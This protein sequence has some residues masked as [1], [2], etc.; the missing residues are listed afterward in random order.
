MFEQHK[1][2]KFDEIFAPQWWN[3]P[4][5]KAPKGRKEVKFENFV[6]F[7]LPLFSSCF[8]LFFSFCLCKRLLVSST[9]RWFLLLAKWRNSAHSSF[10]FFSFFREEIFPEAWSFKLFASLSK[11]VM[12]LKFFLL[13]VFYTKFKVSLDLTFKS[14]NLLIV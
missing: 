5:R 12:F 11:V 13:R 7:E 6:K 10:D 2:E 1:R 14:F 8:P 3:A 9:F 4:G